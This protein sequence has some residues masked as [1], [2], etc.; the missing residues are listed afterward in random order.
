MWNEYL[1]PGSLD[2]AL[3]R[4]WSL[5][6]DVAEAC[7]E[8]RGLEGDPRQFAH[9]VYAALLGILAIEHAERIGGEQILEDYVDPMLDRLLG[10]S[11]PKENP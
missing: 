8:D 11:G 6:Y 4:S 7:A 3:E 1:A 2:E 10:L 5:V 9:L